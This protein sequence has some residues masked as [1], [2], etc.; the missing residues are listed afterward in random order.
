M[1]RYPRVALARLGLLSCLTMLSTT[2]AAAPPANVIAG[3]A[4]DERPLVTGLGPTMLRVSGL[5]AGRL[6]ASDAFA[7]DADGVELDA[8]THA[9]LLARVGLA[10]SSYEAL[11]PW[12]LGADLELDAFSG[13]VTD[14]PELAGDGLPNSGGHDAAV[15]RNANVT[16]SYEGVVALKAGVMT[17]HW[18]LGLVANDGAHRWRPGSA[19][20]IDPR[21]GDRVLR[22][23]LVVQTPGELKI[24]AA[25]G[26]DEVLDDDVLLSGDAARQV[27]LATFVDA[28]GIRGGFY[29]VARF[30]ESASGADLTAIVFDFFADVEAE[31]GDALTL[32]VGGELAAVFGST[33]LAGSPDFPEHDLLQVG[34]VARI[35]LAAQNAGGVLDVVYASGDQDLGDGEQNA[36]K[37]DPNFTLGVVLF[38]YVV[39]AQTGRATYTAQA[40]ELT[41]YPPDD[42]E[43]FPTRGSVSNT[44][45]FFPRFWFRPLAGLEIYGG[46]LIAL[47]AVPPTDPLNTKLAGGDPRNARNAAPSSYLGT[48]LDLGARYRMIAWGSELTL[49]L[50][51]GVLFPGA[52]LEG[53]GF[54]SGSSIGAVRAMLS[55]TL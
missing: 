21:G 14:G 33:T 3:D 4:E 23:Q 40:P 27:V 43:R 24:G 42:L 38:P 29:G 26:F 6:E 49:G 22:G 34:G 1:K 31:V 46:P 9:N 45:A 30:Q 39:A 8:G 51:G 11:A 37:A 54:G 36:F 44:V 32:K 53:A 7:V 55:W 28:P 18:G 12:Y 50:E 2:A 20:F 41:G 13:L 47:A 48:E 16:L 5:L 52:G 35:S 15:I 19:T 25:L 10:W 17:S